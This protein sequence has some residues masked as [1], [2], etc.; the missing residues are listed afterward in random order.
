MANGPK[1]ADERADSATPGAPR[2][3]VAVPRGQDGVPLSPLHEGRFGRMFRD[4][5]PLRP[6]DAA[7]SALAKLV[8][9]SGSA[10]SGDNAKIPAGYTYLGQFVDHDITFDP[11]SKLQKDN[12]PDALVDFR[13]PRFDLDCLYGSGPEDDPFMYEWS[14][15]SNRGVKLLVGRNPTTSG[16]FD[17]DDLPRN[18]QARALIGDPRNDENIVVSQLQL[19]FI[20][21]HNKVVDR[22]RKNQRL[23]GA[24]LFAEAQRIARWH[25]QWIVVHDFLER[26]VGKEMAQAVLKPGT[27][28]KPAETDIRFFSWQNNP[29]MPVEFSGAAYRFGHSQVRAAYDLND[30]VTGVPIFAAADKPGPLEHLGGFR[31][32]P[33]IWTIDWPFFFKTTAGATPQLSRKIDTS[34]AAPLFKLP[35]LPG[36]RPSLPLLNLKRGRALGLPSGQDIAAAIG[37]APLSTA[38]LGLSKIELAPEARAQL[39]AATPLWYYV[40]RE[41]AVQGKGERLGTVGGRIVAEVLVGLL[42]ADPQS[43]L[44]RKPTW[45]PILPSAK[46]G[47]F[48]MPDLV[49]FALD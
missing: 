13:T 16:A 23:A 47:E 20:R 38:Q 39:E 4:P 29:F 49:K 36:N 31:R 19:L 35:G 40:L 5:Q 10:A 42:A 6:D 28:T 8:K 7:L 45:K 37:A 24:A 14:S 43:Y 3:G 15:P 1:D 33:A 9:E 11:L 26:I 32:L 18:Q 44:S 22:T 34:I 27:A 2:H 12:D 25:Y 48:T 21:F 17:R 46:K 41:A 30:T